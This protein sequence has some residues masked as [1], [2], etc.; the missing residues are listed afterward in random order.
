MFGQ[1]PRQGSSTIIILQKLAHARILDSQKGLNG[2][3]RLA[4]PPHRVTLHEIL[5]AIE[6]VPRDFAGEKADSEHLPTRVYKQFVEISE[7]Y[8]GFL[9][10][11]TLA[12]LARHQDTPTPPISDGTPR[13]DRDRSAD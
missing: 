10:S 5:V 2:G 8:Y 12:D 3:F 13:P 6:A 7:M 11:T 1:L 4:R 9:K